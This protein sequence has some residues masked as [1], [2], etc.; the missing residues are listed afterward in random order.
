MFVFLQA[1]TQASVSDSKEPEPD[2]P[3]AF[4]AGPV[5]PQHPGLQS[6]VMPHLRALQQGGHAALQLHIW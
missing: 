6:D 5:P 3:A 2:A 1:A 4:I